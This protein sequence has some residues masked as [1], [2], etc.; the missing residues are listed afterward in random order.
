MDG[1]TRLKRVELLTEINKLRKFASCWLYSANV[2]S[3]K[4][5]VHNITV[6][7]N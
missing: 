7:G 5:V 4:L 3:V 2:I 6:P 1:K